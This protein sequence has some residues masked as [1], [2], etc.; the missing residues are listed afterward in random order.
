[1]HGRGFPGSQHQRTR[2]PPEQEKTDSSE[3]LL[4]LNATSSKPRCLIS[5]FPTLPLKRGQC[6]RLQLFLMLPLLRGV[7]ASNSQRQFGV[8]TDMNPGIFSLSSHNYQQLWLPL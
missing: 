2:S 4:F 6:A 3:P 5:A 7:G 8:D 1:M